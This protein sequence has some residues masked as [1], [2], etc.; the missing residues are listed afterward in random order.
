MA[1]TTKQLRTIKVGEKMTFHCRNAKDFRNGKIYVS[2]T[3]L[4]FR[5]EDK[6]TLRILKSD[7]DELSITVIA[8]AY[9]PIKPE[10][11]QHEKRI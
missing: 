4:N 2:N 8:E 11:K 3:S 1:V 10:R 5:D 9:K 6:K 7:R